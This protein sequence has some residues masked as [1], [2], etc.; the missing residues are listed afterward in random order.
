MLSESA[1]KLQDLR[2]LYGKAK[3]TLRYTAL[4][5]RCG[6]IAPQQS[7]SSLIAVCAILSRRHIERKGVKKA[8]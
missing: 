4:P 8:A 7:E 3:L 5:P 6:Q 1:P 2:E